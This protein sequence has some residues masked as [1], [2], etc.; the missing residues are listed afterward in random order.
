MTPAPRDV[1]SP[2]RPTVCSLIIRAPFAQVSVL[3]A[4]K[5]PFT[6]DLCQQADRPGPEFRGVTQC[7][8]GL[9]AVEIDALVDMAQQQLAAVLEVAV[10]D[11]DH[12]LAAVGQHPEQ[13]VLH[14]PELAAHDLP[15]AAALRE[16]ER[17]ELLL[18]AELQGEELVDERNVVVQLADLEQPLHAQPG[19][20]IPVP[21]LIHRVA[22]VPLLAELAS[23]P[24]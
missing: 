10:L 6:F 8:T 3:A 9:G 23:V 7:V 22:L 20:A 19:P 5:L 2:S 14:L 16:P 21:L 15:V 1:P 17:V 11:H 4:Q 13:L 18:D 24:P 12:R